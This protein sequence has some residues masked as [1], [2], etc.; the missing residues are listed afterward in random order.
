LTHV[1]KI[2]VRLITGDIEDASTN[3]R[4]YLGL[5]GREFRLDKPGNQFQRANVDNF[6]I[7]D[8]SNIE[9]PD[10]VNTL[11]ALGNNN[12]PRVEFEDL[13]NYPT[14]IRFEPRNKND[15]WNIEDVNVEVIQYN[16]SPLGSTVNKKTFVDLEGNVWLGVR[17]GLFLYLAQFE[18]FNPKITY[19]PSKM[20][21]FSIGYLEYSDADIKGDVYYPI[22]ATGPFP[23]I[24]MAHGNH[25]IFYNPADRDQESCTQNP[26]WI[27]IPN[28]KGYV[29]FQKQ[30]ARMGIIVVSVDCNSTNCFGGGVLNIEERADL[31]IGSIDHFRTLNG[32]AT[33]ILNNKI[34][35]QLVGLM[36]HS[37]G[38]DAV[39]LVPER[40][41]FPGVV[42]KCV[43]SLAPTDFGASTGQPQGYSF[44]TILPAGDGDVKRND[45]AKF[46]DKAVPGPFKCQSYVHHTNH[47]FFNR[48]W[49]SDDSGGGPPPVMLRSDHE[50]ILSAYGAAFFRYSLLNHNYVVRFLTMYSL[51]KDVHFENVHLSFQFN[52]SFVVDNH[53]ESNTIN[54]NSVNLPTTQTGSITADEF[55]FRQGGGSFNGSFFGN[56]VGM[57]MTDNGINGIFRSQ[58]PPNTSLKGKEI[59]LR[60]AEV[61]NMN[62]SLPMGGTGFQLG[63]E[64]KNGIQVWVD[65][66]EVG[67]LPRPYLREISRTKTML[68]TLRFSSLCFIHKNP[69]LNINDI[70]FFLIR[71]NRGDNR[72]LAFDDLEIVQI[73][74]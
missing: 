29:Y 55:L 60:T 6:I 9:N 11:P 20:D 51:P 61:Y 43:I 26:G 74:K 5:G 13:A 31:I 4:V 71:T 53:E 70:R 35:F 38:G 19:D 48:E 16:D 72:A 52:D 18:C 65:S 1:G 63:I 33:S 64:D 37:R 40:I 8:G 7:G 24:F 47:N 68:K 66:D 57:V 49:P 30:L 69:E 62:A 21:L 22:E 23:I 32:D 14:Y 15:N 45:G 42:I 3:G 36:G 58:L 59:W 17:S 27:E 34:D 28:H 41:T 46:Y 50:Q 25:S 54:V 39:V 2:I 73:L 10:N 56:S 44:M 67:P 12:S